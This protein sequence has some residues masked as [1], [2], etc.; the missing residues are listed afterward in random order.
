[1]NLHKRDLAFQAELQRWVE[2]GQISFEPGQQLDEQDDQ[3]DALPEHCVPVET[4]VAGNVWQVTTEAGE[5]VKS[6]DLV[7]VIES[8]KME[9]QV[10]APA[11]G[12]V[13]S[14]RKPA[15]SQVNAGA[16]LIWISTESP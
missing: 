10:A 2:T 5:S 13:H 4:P 7:A 9:I 16:D 11:D 14:I 3:S 6:G 15:G 8:M 1:M 12:I